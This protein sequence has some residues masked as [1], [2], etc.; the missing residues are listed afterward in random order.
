MSCRVV[1]CC[2]VSCC[3]VSCQVLLCHISCHNMSYHKLAM[4]LLSCQVASCHVTH[5]KL[6]HVVSCR[7]ISCHAMFTLR[8]LTLS[9]FQAL[10]I[11]PQGWQGCQNDQK[12]LRISTKVVWWST[13]QPN[14]NYCCFLT[15]LAKFWCKNGQFFALC[16]S[17]FNFGWMVDH[18]TNLIEILRFF[19]SFWHLYQPWGCISSGD[20]GNSFN[21]LA[22][23]LQ[24]RHI[25]LL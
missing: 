7:V 4:F 25:V 24:Q 12:S 5:V 19:W 22:I 1:S 14:L 13:I 6:S 23:Y 20:I 10:L 11:H 15:K 9:L 18:Q 21:F 8:D 2:V 16:W 17:F 3:V